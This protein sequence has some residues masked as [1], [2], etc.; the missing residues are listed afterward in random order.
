MRKA[1]V[2]SVL[3]AFI[4]LLG[5]LLP[6]ADYAEAAVLLG[7]QARI[8]PTGEASGC[9]ADGR[10][11]TGFG[12]ADRSRQPG[13]YELQGE[14]MVLG[15]GHGE[16]RVC[17][18]VHKPPHTL[19]SCADLAGGGAGQVEWINPRGRSSVERLEWAVGGLDMVQFSGGVDGSWTGGLLQV[20]RHSCVI[21]N[22]RPQG[23]AA[24]RGVTAHLNWVP[25]PRAPREQHWSEH[26]GKR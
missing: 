2:L 13:W 21:H 6:L 17:G 3:G 23:A 25:A 19:T 10:L 20:A 14:I 7:G 11:L 12:P 9:T 22:G 15:H 18:P 5:M 8:V 16:V 4:S 24:L 1:T 26:A